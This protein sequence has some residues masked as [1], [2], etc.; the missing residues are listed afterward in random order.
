MPVTRI[1]VTFRGVYVNNSADWFGP[2][3]WHF[4]AKI[5]GKPVGDP[6]V[7]WEARTGQWIMLPE[8]KWSAEVDLLGKKP[9]DKVEVSFR[10]KDVDLISDDD[11]GEAKLTLKYPFQTERDAPSLAP[12]AAGVT[13]SAAA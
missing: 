8:K 7:E 11:L 6:N 5:N 2:G 12:G 4:T 9:G 13:T 3:E 10:G 1:K